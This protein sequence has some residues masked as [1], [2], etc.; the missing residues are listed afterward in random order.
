MSLELKTAEYLLLIVPRV[1]LELTHISAQV[2][3]TCVATI[4]PPGLFVAGTGLEP[5]TFGLCYASEKEA[6]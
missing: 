6:R 2:P 3:K 4:T 1:R 5:V